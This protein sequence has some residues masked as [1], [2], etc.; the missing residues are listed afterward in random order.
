MECDCDE[1]M[2][3]S[4]A[5]MTTM[6]L[7]T[8][9][10][11]YLFQ[12]NLHFTGEP[13][14]INHEELFEL[15]NVV[16]I[17]DIITHNPEPTNRNEGRKNSSEVSTL[18]FPSYSGY[19]NIAG[20][21]TGISRRTSGSY[22]A[23]TARVTPIQAIPTIST[24]EPVRNAALEFLE[25]RASPRVTRYSSM[26]TPTLPRR[27]DAHTVELKSTLEDDDFFGSD[28]E[29]LDREIPPQLTNDDLASTRS[30]YSTA[31]IQPL[32]T[33][34][35]PKL[36]PKLRVANKVN[37]VTQTSYIEVC[38]A[39][40]GTHDDVYYRSEATQ[41]QVPPKEDKKKTCELSIGTDPEPRM[42]KKVTTTKT[43]TTASQ[44]ETTETT[45][46][47]TNSQSSGTEDTYV[48]LIDACVG[49]DS[50]EFF[51]KPVSRGSQSTQKGRKRK[52]KLTCSMGVGTEG[53]TR[54][55]TP[56]IARKKKTPKII[57]D[58]VE[59]IPPTKITRSPSP[60]PRSSSSLSNRIKEPPDPIIETLHNAFF[61][62]ARYG[63]VNSEGREMNNKNWAKLCRDCD[64]IDNKNVLVGDIDVIFS[65]HKPK[66]TRLVEFE[67]FMNCL[68][69]IADRVI[70]SKVKDEKLRREIIYNRV[71]GKAPEYVGITSVSKTGNV[72]RM[73]D[74]TLYPVSHKMRF[75]EEGRGLGVDD[76]FD[77]PDTMMGYVNGYTGRNQYDLKM[78]SSSIRP[79]TSSNGSTTKRPVSSS[80]T[81]RTHTPVI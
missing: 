76:K 44:S 35:E 25:R 24:P 45:P 38:D 59:D 49:T 3:F 52:K 72:D 79:R 22:G 58:T 36:S 40:V 9:Q 17:D 67:M 11:N 30:I 12:I 10:T 64:F 2:R 61:R 60:A 41:V 13:E 20:F 47:T 69:E 50:D 31:Q 63:E 62:F 57:T 37:T 65:R 34:E 71:I 39:C 80:S 42:V 1:T 28:L 14:D 51:S 66:G 26:L 19:R 21:G 4:D 56:E 81:Y 48:M 74:H 43:S 75:D 7:M 29:S 68:N 33:L 8:S 77:V 27:Q 15:P 73:T 46:T 23:P 78:Q 16:S 5:I 6:C 32:T 53:I 18:I 54:A 70:G 55:R